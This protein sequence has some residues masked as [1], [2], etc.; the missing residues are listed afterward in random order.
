MLLAALTTL[1]RTVS[2]MRG[3][4]RMARDTVAWEMPRWAAISRMVQAGGR[5]IGEETALWWRFLQ[6]DAT[7]A[8]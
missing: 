1:S 2:V 4:L 8:Q 3:S 7:G 6:V 5:F